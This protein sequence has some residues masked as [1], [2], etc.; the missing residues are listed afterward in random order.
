VTISADATIAER[1]G[2]ENRNFP[3]RFASSTWEVM[4]WGFLPMNATTAPT[5]PEGINQWEWMR[6]IWY[7]WMSRHEHH[8][9]LIRNNGSWTIA[10]NEWR[11][12]EYIPVVDDKRWKRYG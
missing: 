11:S 3:N 2:R 7:W 4:T 1:R 9:S 8:N 5:S 12:A 6:W 10:T